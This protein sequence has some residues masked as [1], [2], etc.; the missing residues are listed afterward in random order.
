LSEYY[1]NA[2]LHNAAQLY[3]SSRTVFGHKINTL[4][5]LAVIIV[6]TQ[7]ISDSTCLRER[8]F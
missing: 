3:V 6:G 2:K 7:Q 1:R 4:F 8:Q 5:L